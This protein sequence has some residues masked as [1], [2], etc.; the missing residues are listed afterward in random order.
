[1]LV[2]LSAITDPETVSRLVRSGVAGLAHQ[3]Q[4]IEQIAAALD[5]IEAGRNVLDPGPLRPPARD[6]NRLCQLS[7]REQEILTRIVGGQ[8]TSQM[9]YAMNITANTV[10]TY[11]KN[12]LAK[13]G[14]H[15]R[16][17]LAAL[18]SR[19]GL[20]IDQASAADDFP[21]G[22]RVTRSRHIPLTEERA[23][24]RKW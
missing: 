15:S 8:S 4:S 21:A 9:A 18:A 1:V 23:R 13:L 22:K 3:D 24:A 5:A 14:A 20:L 17:Q 11:V 6:R 10:R 7:P 16:L 19:D 2:L 12:V